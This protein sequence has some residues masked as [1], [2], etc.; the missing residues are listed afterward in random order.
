MIGDQTLF[1]GAATV[2]IVIGL[3]II[4]LSYRSMANYQVEERLTKFVVERTDKPKDRGFSLRG[5]DFSESFLQR[6]ILPMLN[7]FVSFF[8]RFTPAQTMEQVN[9]Q[10]M[11]AGNPFGLK[12]QPFY[13]IRFVLIITGLIWTFFH[14]R[15]VP[16]NN[17]LLID[18]LIILFLF[19]SPML[20]LRLR[21]NRRQED[22]RKGLP[23]VLD[24]LSVC[25]AAGLSFD[26]AM[27]RVGASYQTTIGREFSRLV[28]EMEVGVSR[29]KALR[30]LAY[31]INISELSSFV[32]IILQSEQL[33]MSIADVLHAQAEQ[34]RIQ[35]QYRVK[36]IAQKLPA[37]MMIPL[38]LLILPALL[39]VL[40][41]PSIPAILEIF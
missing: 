7:S 18:V 37:K 22:V 17:T 39:A 21:I 33:G 8:G 32:A 20:W 9:R 36:E 11:M 10:L 29:Q 38:A 4:L 19:I 31:R 2:F 6:T 25:T 3:T 23:D 35:R 30:N 27:Q 34:M 41:G 14:Y 1:I 40:L 24:M 26:Q 16:T 5:R 13:G 28:A 12:A 15:A